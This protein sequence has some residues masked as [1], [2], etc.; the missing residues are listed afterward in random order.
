MTG[1]EVP[2]PSPAQTESVFGSDDR[3]AVG[4]TTAFPWAAIG[5]VA[6]STANGMFFGTGFLIGPQHML[7]AGHVVE[8]DLYGGDGRAQAITVAFGQAGSLKPFAEVEALD[9]RTPEGWSAGQDS[10]QDWALVTLDRSIGAAIGSFDL[11]APSAPVGETVTLAGYPGDLG[12]TDL[13]AAAG[14]IAAADA[15]RLYYAGTLDTEGG[16]SGAPIWRS[17]P[18]SGRREA[19]GVHAAGAV[20]PEAPGAQNSGT[21]L[22]PERLT[23]ID[24]WIGQD[25]FLAPPTD[26]P[27]LVDADAA[28]G[29]VTAAVSAVTA[30]AGERLALS[31][32]IANLG[33]AT[34]A[35]PEITAYLSQNDVLTEFDLA[36]G[37]ATLAPLAPFESRRITL[38][39][40]LPA[41]VPSGFWRVGWRLTEGGGLPEFDADNNDGLLPR[42][43]EVTA[44][45]DA[46]AEALELAGAVLAPG[47]ALTGSWTLRNLGGAAAPIGSSLVLS[48]DAEFGPGD[49]VLASLPAVL[50]GAGQATTVTLPGGIALPADLASGTYYLAA[51]ADF[52]DVV[53]EAVESNNASSARAVTVGAP[54]LDLPGSD[55]PETLIGSDGDDTVRAFNGDDVVDAG[56]GRDVIDAGGDN[57]LVFARAG[58]D[59]ILG[60]PGFDTLLGERGDDLIEGDL[61][62]GVKGQGDELN[63]GPGDDTL[64]GEGGPDTLFGSDGDDLLDGGPGFDRLGGNAGADTLI[65]GDLRDTLD[66]GADADSILGG[67]G[68]DEIYGGTGADTVEAGP[69]PDFV[70]GGDGNDDISTGTEDDIV[71]A[72][73]GDDTVR[74]GDGVDRLQGNDGADLLLGEA[75]G[76][77]L[78]GGPGADTAE[79][80]AGADLI[81]GN[82]GDDRL[83]GG[84]GADTLR[85]EAGDDFLE[86]GDGAD[87]LGG[88]AGA[89][90]LI[91]GAG[92][93]RLDGVDGDDLLEGGDGI[94]AVLGSAGRDSLFGGPGADSVFGGADDD[95]VSGGLGADL[96]A[97]GDGADRFE[98]AVGDGSDLVFDFTPGT[99]VLVLSGGVTR[100]GDLVQGIDAAGWLTIG[101]GD[102]SDVIAL[103]GVKPGDLND[104]GSLVFL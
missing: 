33:T 1:Q 92:D 101:Y 31:L 12:G 42:S 27:D 86:G 9:F 77:R 50:L 41:N 39:I 38:D 85:G 37:A 8:S 4:D 32:T 68:N 65:G 63:G 14:E 51:F 90:T 100:F 26:L 54:G 49:L 72:G 74:G 23:Q 60:G 5:R 62:D 46:V 96:L 2:G 11:A 19:V 55:A 82:D 40:D 102:P 79:G 29:T 94:D 66:G 70:D 61:G 87:A 83:L 84:E 103:Q 24:E 18:S 47:E 98:F 53:A 3:L 22:T 56:P 59:S 48:D 95:T 21:R 17:F 13:Y 67:D 69:G 34:A 64:R 16:M 20:D 57:D 35:A 15:E 81:F 43:L 78:F 80:G 6:V 30:A 75:G 97:G 25:A 58:D 73:A 10:A 93:D 76:D 88:A 99:D 71:I 91:G 89:D 36:I 28:F 45:P 7:T 44:R 52:G 104:D